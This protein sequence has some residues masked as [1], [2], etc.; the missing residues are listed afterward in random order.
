[1]FSDSLGDV[2]PGSSAGLI[3]EDTRFLSRWEL[4]LG[5]RRLSL[6]K[7]G[8]V[9]YYSAA[10]FLTN[11]ELPGL[12]ANSLAIRRM[13]FVGHGALEQLSVFNTAPEP[14]AFELRLACGADF[15]DL[16]EVRSSVRDR[17]ASIG[18]VAGDRTLRFRYRV[19]GFEA[20][21]TVRIERSEILESSSEEV[22]ARASP[23]IDGSD[24]V[25][26]LELPPRCALTAVAKVGVRVNNVAFEP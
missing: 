15:A 17:S 26:E 19:P 1:M 16:F 9:N 23:R 14:V 24:V 10:F 13:R 4:I 3:H 12:R 22:L 20:E 25:W 18:R 11:P 8:T 6:L 5:G 7:S 2:P 21:T